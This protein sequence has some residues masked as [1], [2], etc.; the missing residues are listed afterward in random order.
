MWWESAAAGLLVS[1]L[2]ISALYYAQE[3]SQWSGCSRAQNSAISCWCANIDKGT[4]KLLNIWKDIRISNTEYQT[5]YIFKLHWHCRSQQYILQT[6][7]QRKYIFSIFIENFTFPTRLEEHYRQG[8]RRKT[9]VVLHLKIQ[10]SC[11]YWYSRLKLLLL[12]SHI[13][14]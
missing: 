8:P 7:N 9:K 3:W 13:F 4:S 6:Q 1:S 10:F 11:C 12:G 2:A 5:N 14:F